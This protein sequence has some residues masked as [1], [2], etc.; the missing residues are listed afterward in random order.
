ME[1]DPMTVVVR[2]Q[3]EVLRNYR[4]VR[5]RALPEEVLEIV[6]GIATSGLYFHDWDKLQPVVS[7]LIDEVVTASNAKVPDCPDRPAEGFADK[8]AALLSAVAAFDDAPFTI[9][10]L[11]EVLLEPSRFYSST[12]KLFASLDK[13]LA[14]SSTQLPSDPALYT[15][16]A[17]AARE[18]AAKEEADGAGGGAVGAEG[19]EDA[20][21]GAGAGAGAAASAA[22]GGGGGGGGGDVEPMEEDGSGG[23]DGVAE[24]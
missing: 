24:G 20:G 19:K 2:A 21:S 8:R 6:R 15:V 14:V 9:Q 16:A 23:G 10:R 3:E 18:A 11:C 4:H 7:A 13:L 5:G 22:D 12:H 17:P 1:G